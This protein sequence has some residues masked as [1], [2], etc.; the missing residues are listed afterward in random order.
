VLKV[1]NIMVFIFHGFYL[2]GVVTFVSHYATSMW[3]DLIALF[4]NV[5]LEFS[6]YDLLK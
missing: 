4:V 3:H 1:A 6:A 2:N 5:L